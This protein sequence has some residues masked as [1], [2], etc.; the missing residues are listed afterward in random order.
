[1]S[2]DMNNAYEDAVS[3]AETV[4]RTSKRALESDDPARWKKALEMFVESIPK[5]LEEIRAEVDAMG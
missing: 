2:Y 4:V 5:G 1:M 3:V